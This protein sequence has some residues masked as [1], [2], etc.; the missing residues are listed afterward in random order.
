M[1]KKFLIICMLF[2]V[3]QTSFAAKHFVRMYYQHRN[4]S[5]KTVHVNRAP[6]RIPIDVVYD[7][8]TN[9]LEIIGPESLQAEIYIYDMS[10]T[11]EDY[12]LSLNSVFYML[13]PGTHVI[14]IKGN[15]WEAEGTLEL[16]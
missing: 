15:G 3:A 8:D 16:Q 14:L 4:L 2:L 6:M 10:G 7:S 11:L 5:G 13:K 9:I 1:K 12:S